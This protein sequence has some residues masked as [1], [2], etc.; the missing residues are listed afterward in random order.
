MASLTS[1][2]FGVFND[3]NFSLINAIGNF[4]ISLIANIFTGYLLEK[5]I[6]K[7]GACVLIC[8]FKILL[9]IPTLYFVFL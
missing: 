7:P 8:A 4:V 1:K 3:P 2:Y 9:E 5:F 6:E